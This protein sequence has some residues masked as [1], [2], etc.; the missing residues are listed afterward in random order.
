MD[1][2]QIVP[3]YVIYHTFF[4]TVLPELLDDYVNLTQPTGSNARIQ[5]N[6]KDK[7]ISKVSIKWLKNGKELKVDGNRLVSLPVTLRGETDRNA[8][9]VIRLKVYGTLHIY[10]LNKEDEGEYT[11]IVENPWGSDSKEIAS[12]IL[13]DNSPN[14][15]ISKPSDLLLYEETLLGVFECFTSFKSKITW[16]FTGELSF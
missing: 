12:I 9:Y 5:C 2:C 15:L 14:N 7:V 3:C 11:C 10:N 8:E 1:R 13:N 4:S 16:T 6:L